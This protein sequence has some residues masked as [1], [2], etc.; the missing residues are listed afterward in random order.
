ME[1]WASQ[2]RR[3]G[4]RR[5]HGVLTRARL[6]GKHVERRRSWRQHY[7][8]IEYRTATGETISAREDVAPALYQRVRVG[9]TISV[10]YL[11]ADPDVHALGATARSDTLMLW[12]AGLWFVLAGVYLL[13]GK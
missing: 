12:M 4:S 13:F 8:D 5:A 11:P 6:S 2:W 3:A 10:R 9:D 7:I 1:R